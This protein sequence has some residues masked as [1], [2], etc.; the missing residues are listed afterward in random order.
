M[1]NFGRENFDD[2]TCIQQIRQTFP[3]SKFYA[4]GY[5][6]INCYRIKPNK[7]T[8]IKMIPLVKVEMIPLVKAA[9]ET[10]SEE[11]PFKLK[12]TSS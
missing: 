11:E 3:P 6:C 9:D 1:Q 5:L 2:S 8:A 10:Q 7:P 12:V 4:I